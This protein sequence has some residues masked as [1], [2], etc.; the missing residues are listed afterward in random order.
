MICIIILLTSFFSRATQARQVPKT[1]ESQRIVDETT[2]AAD[3][4]EVANDQATDELSAYF[5]GKRPKILVTTS[6]KAIGVRV[7]ARLS[8]SSLPISR[9]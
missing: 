9:Y 4:E 7:R 2:V 1:I 8:H 5:N 6:E 3:D